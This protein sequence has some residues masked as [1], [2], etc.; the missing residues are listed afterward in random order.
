MALG[1]VIHPSFY[2]F[3]LLNLR[4]SNA[5]VHTIQNKWYGKYHMKFKKKQKPSNNIEA[6]M[7]NW[8]SGISLIPNFLSQISTKKNTIR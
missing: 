1:K 7:Y 3:F 8:K 6:K 4:Y 2:F 5:Q